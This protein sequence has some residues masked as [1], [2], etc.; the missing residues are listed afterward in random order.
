[1]TDKWVWGWTGLLMTDSQF[2][3]DYQLSQIA[4]AFDPFQTGLASEGVSQL[5]LSGAGDRSYFDIR[6]IYYLRLLRAR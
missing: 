1:M 6:S 3:Y 5:Y 2:L 4:G